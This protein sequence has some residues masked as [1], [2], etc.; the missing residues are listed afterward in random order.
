MPEPPRTYY[1]PP[2]QI[3]QLLE[4]ITQPS[5]KLPAVYAIIG[6]PLSGKTEAVRYLQHELDSRRSPAVIDILTY[7]L[8]E[9]SFKEIHK[10]LRSHRLLVKER[11]KQSVL[12]DL[13]KH[14]HLLEYQQS[15]Y[16]DPRSVPLQLLHDIQ[17]TQELLDSLN[18]DIALHSTQ[19]YI[20]ID[21]I[22]VIPSGD[23]KFALDLFERMSSSGGQIALVCTSRKSL[24]K[25]GI[26]PEKLRFV[27]KNL[28]RLSKV[29]L[30]KQSLDHMRSL[31][32]PHERNQ[33]EQ[34]LA[35][36]AVLPSAVEFDVLCALSA[37]EPDD[38]RALLNKLSRWFPEDEDEYTLTHPSFCQYLL[39]RPAFASRIHRHRRRVEA[40]YR[41]PFLNQH[42]VDSV[43]SCILRNL[44]EMFLATEQGLSLL[45]QRDWRWQEALG[46]RY[47]ANAAR[48]AFL[49][50]LNQIQSHTNETIHRVMQYSTLLL[51][52]ITVYN[53]E[54]PSLIESE[55][56]SQPDTQASDPWGQWI[57]A[58]RNLSASD[59]NAIISEYDELLQTISTEWRTTEPR[60]A[61]HEYI[62]L[63]QELSW[64]P[65]TNYLDTLSILAPALRENFEQT[66]VTGLFKA[67]EL[68]AQNYPDTITED[69]INLLRVTLL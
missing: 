18:P 36:F 59:S 27:S 40:Y 45:T 31:C 67:I 9:Y 6:E 19:L 53:S 8:T 30:W 1:T 20:F 49:R 24:D 17:R 5:V 47:H 48:Q 33:V 42:H 65:L 52:N 62:R 35:L 21:D 55:T 50:A 41:M 22:D 57:Q 58:I 15:M 11:E 37:I 32:T 39:S 12:E 28:Q 16:A 63:L 3:R 69:R 54:T 14:L 68:F 4:E 26:T 34:L 66:V 46:K 43:P 23:F 29:D 51:I 13:K 56:K 7:S 44:P 2:D 38:L 10:E 25:L 60:Q 64:L 61:T